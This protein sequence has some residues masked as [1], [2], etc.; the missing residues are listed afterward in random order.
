LLY[1]EEGRKR[2]VALRRPFSLHS[3]Y[4]VTPK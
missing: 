1:A 2:M 4:G 3:T